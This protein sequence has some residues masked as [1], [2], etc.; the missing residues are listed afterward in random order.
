MVP[1]SVVDKETNGSYLFARTK[2]TTSV[3]FFVNK[4][5]NDKHPLHDEQTVK[6]IAWASVFRL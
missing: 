5:T 4:R 1:T 2:R 3:C 6:L